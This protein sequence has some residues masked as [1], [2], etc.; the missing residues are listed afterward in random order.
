MSARGTAGIIRVATVRTTRVLT[1]DN[2][3]ANL[4]DPALMDE[5]RVRLQEADVHPE[6]RAVLLTGAGESFCGGLDI[7][8]I[9]AGA[10]PADFAVALAELLRVVPRL[11]IAVAAAVN[12]DALASGA[13][14]VAAADYA[15][16]NDAVRIG[17]VEVS[18]G[19]WPMI[20]QVPVIQRLGPRAAIENIGSGEPFTAQRSLEVG[21]VQRVVAAGGEVPAALEWLDLA[22]RA[23]AATPDG[24]RSLY[25]FAQMSYDDALD[26]SVP[27]FLTLFD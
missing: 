5:L 13:S 15:V 24:R 6:V 18:V 12:G 26:A 22:S 20:A 14:L 21:L 23:P 1:I 7:G 10:S 8:A 9:K 2:G 3:P 16:A 11:G 17:T 27:R 4:L 19:M 25:E